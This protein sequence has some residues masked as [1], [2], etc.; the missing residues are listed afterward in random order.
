[1]EKYKRRAADLGTF[2]LSH[3]DVDSAEEYQKGSEAQMREVVVVSQGDP[4]VQTA[5]THAERMSYESTSE[6]TSHRTREE[7]Q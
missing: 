6:L 1:M 4:A 5:S 7:R 2:G 3:I